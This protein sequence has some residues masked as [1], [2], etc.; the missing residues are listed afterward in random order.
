MFSIDR[1]SEN[2]MQNNTLCK[3][4]DVTRVLNSIEKIFSTH[5][6]ILLQHALVLQE[7]S[8]ASRSMTSLSV[9]FNTTTPN[10]MRIVRYLRDSGYIEIDTTRENKY[11]YHNQYLILTKKGQ[12][13]LETISESEYIPLFEIKR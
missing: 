7:L 12:K 10:M 5:F 13:L 11:H 6:G 2:K 4:I 9:L 3:L 1:R 8:E